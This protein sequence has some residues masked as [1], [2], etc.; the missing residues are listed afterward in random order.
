M[1]DLIGRTLKGKFLITARLGEGA[2]GTVYRG[3]QTSTR[4]DVAIKIMHPGL[5]QEPGMLTR[6]RREATA[7]R[8]VRHP[9]AVEVVAHGVDQGIV[10]LAMELIDGSDLGE[11]LAKGE[12]IAVARAVRIVADV[13]SA[14]SLAHAQGLVHRDI[15]PENI[16]LAG[17]TGDTA[18]L[19]D[20]GIA[21]SGVQLVGTEPEHGA[22]YDEGSTD[23]S[24]PDSLDLATGFDLTTTGTLVGSPGYMAPEQWS[25]HAVDARTDIYACG[26]LLYQL[27]TGRLPFEDENPF[28]IATRQ[29]SERPVAPHALNP[30]VSA[31]LSEIALRALRPDPAERFQ[32]AAEMSEALRSHL[33]EHAIASTLGLDATLPLGL[34]SPLPVKMNVTLDLHMPLDL[35][36]PLVPYAPLDCT[37][38]LNEL[39]APIASLGNAPPPVGTIPAQPA[40]VHSVARNGRTTPVP[41]ASLARTSSPA[42]PA[43]RA[44]LVAAQ[45]RVLLALAAA[46]LALGV[47]LGMIVF[48]PMFHH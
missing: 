41:S 5:M 44:R 30:E 19:I 48:F 17:P 32:T 23:D 37:L 28:V 35:Q 24:I 31:S 36:A 27:V 10:F 1:D 46:F 42:L 47:V 45:T 18:K 40:A 29:L 22:V 3:V 20:F 25:S 9:N 21:K 16:M 33:V 7:M 14:L 39:F 2:L 43:R 26:V 11:R 12:R 15:K 8:R 34:P 38:A 13:C 6:F 4:R